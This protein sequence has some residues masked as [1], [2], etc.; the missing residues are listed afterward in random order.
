MV[1][2]ILSSVLRRSLQTSLPLFFWSTV[3]VHLAVS[4]CCS[5]LLART[6]CSAIQP[7][8]FRK[9][10]FFKVGTAGYLQN[11]LFSAS[12][13]KLKIVCYIAMSSVT[14]GLHFLPSRALSHDCWLRCKQIFKRDFFKDCFQGAD[15]AERW[16]SSLPYF[17]SNCSLDFN[18]DVWNSCSC[19]GQ[20]CN[21]GDR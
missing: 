14:T 20:S 1:C 12:L 8:P 15:L 11:D 5:F 10:L 3:Q 16:V 6:L 4:D 21:L 7:N 18:C 2:I 19:I 9:D 17:L 13:S